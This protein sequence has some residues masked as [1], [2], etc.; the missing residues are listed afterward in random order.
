M[1]QQS[2]NTN[3]KINDTMKNFTVTP[4]EEVSKRLSIATKKTVKALDKENKIN[5]KGI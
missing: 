3:R 5:I 2:I 1:T 4:F